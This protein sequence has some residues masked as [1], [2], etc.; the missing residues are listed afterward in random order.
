[1]NGFSFSSLFCT[2]CYTA[3]TDAPKLVPAVGL[4]RVRS[5]LHHFM[6]CTVNA[7]TVA[8]AVGAVVFGYNLGIVLFNVLVK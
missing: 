6:E 1:M 7:V 2:H 4:P 5:V 3:P 8:V